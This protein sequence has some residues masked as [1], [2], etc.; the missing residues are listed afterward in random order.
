MQY[1]DY[2]KMLDIVRSKTDLV[3]ETAIVLGSGLGAL[4]DEIDVHSVVDYKEI[5]DFPVSTVEGHKGRFV[6]GN[7]ED[8]PVV[9]MQGRVHYYEGYP[10]E[11][12]VLPIRLMRL[13]GAEKLILTNASG[14][15]NKDFNAGD[16]MLISDHISS[17]VPNPLIGANIDE[18]GVR[19]PDMSDIYSERMRIKA[20]QTAEKNNIE[21]KEGVYAQFSGPSYECPAEIRM[22]RTVGVDAVGMSTACEAVTAKHCG[23]EVCGI[24]CIS[25]MACDITKIPLSHEEVQECADRTAPIF[26]QLVRELVKTL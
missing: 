1:K 8:K 13:M 6:F 26:K 21:L 23:F 16:L 2:L 15:I 22:L 19:F 4:A 25:N 18:F 3:P 7:I 9:I 11:S 5:P 12:V 10:M 17:F 14:G 24:S 20:K